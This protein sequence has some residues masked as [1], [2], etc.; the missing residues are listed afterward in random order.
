VREVEHPNVREAERH[1][2]REMQQEE[3]DEVQQDAPSA[4][5]HG[6]AMSQSNPPAQHQLIRRGMLVPIPK[7]MPLALRRITFPAAVIQ[8]PVIGYEIALDYSRDEATTTGSTDAS[9]RYQ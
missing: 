8:K 5:P 9:A 2:R 7:P 3:Q 4:P 1:S 6:P